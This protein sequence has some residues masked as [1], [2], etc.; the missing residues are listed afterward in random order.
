MFQTSKIPKYGDLLADSYQ[1][2]TQISQWSYSVSSVLWNISII[3]WHYHFPKS[4]PF[5]FA[6]KN[7]R[8]Y[9]LKNGAIWYRDKIFINDARSI[10][11]IHVS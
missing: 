2:F 7:D 3:M 8:S 4:E 11:G 9:S 10:I 1:L 6:E 5:I